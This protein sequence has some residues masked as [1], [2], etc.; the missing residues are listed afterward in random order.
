MLP[1]VSHLETDP[2]EK[3]I[4]KIEKNGPIQSI[5]INI[6]STGIAQEYQFHL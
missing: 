4:L 6:E 3:T 5:G 1:F 2:N